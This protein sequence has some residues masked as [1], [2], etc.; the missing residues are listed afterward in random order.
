[1]SGE[2]AAKAKSQYL[3]ACIG[4]TIT[5]FTWVAKA[6][7][8]QNM[9]DSSSKHDEP[10]SLP[11]CNS[12]NALTDVGH[13]EPLSLLHLNFA[14]TANCSNGTSSHSGSSYDKPF[15]IAYTNG[16]AYSLFL[17][18]FLAGHPELLRYFLRWLRDA[19]LSFFCGRLCGRPV[20][21]RHQLLNSSLSPPPGALDASDDEAS[22][23]SF[24]KS[25]AS[26]NGAASPSGVV[27][28]PHHKRLHVQAAGEGEEQLP[29]Y[30]AKL[31]PTY[32]RSVKTALV[33][34][35]L[36]LC[37]GWMA[38]ASLSR[39]SLAVN[40]SIWNSGC[41]LV[42]LLEGSFL[43]GHSLRDPQ[44]LLSVMVSLSGVAVLTVA[45][46]RE[47]PKD[48]DSAT[49]TSLVGVLMT[50][51]A[52]LIYSIYEVV[53]KFVSEEQPETGASTTA[54]ADALE[55]AEASAQCAA[56]GELALDIGAPA[57]VGA[58]AAAE[59]AH[60]SDKVQGH[61]AAMGPI[62]GAMLF[63]GTLGMGIA[64]FAWIGLF[65]LDATGVEPWQRPEGSD[66]HMILATMGLDCVLNIA[67]LGSIA[68]S[69]ALFVQCGT[70]L[71]IPVSTLWDFVAHH[72]VPSPL[73]VIG[74]AILVLG[75]LGLNVRLPCL[76]KEKDHG[77]LDHQLD[78]EAAASVAAAEDE[79]EQA[80]GN[81]ARKLR[82]MKVGGSASSSSSG[83]SSLA[84]SPL[85][86]NSDE[87][88]ATRT[89]LRSP[90]L[91]EQ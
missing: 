91:E 18:V 3:L 65:I 73:N 88:T 47:H 32:A 53:F 89:V 69:S 46:T 59:A 45:S 77:T 19:C 6:A 90:L 78:A 7:L 52:M 42:F 31:V 62:W 66:L 44:K 58:L 23:P 24:R 34:S 40:T 10:S 33:L 61:S 25:T 55:D 79:E 1:M 26:V 74:M 49:A 38:N 20:E 14:A 29:T 57:A 28:S 15:F 11:P 36:Y 17:F 5:V 35:L 43:P 67:I 21:A 72:S 39:T 56:E 30:L 87:A 80:S 13:D 48:G 84:P 16:S 71:T 68:L 76:P 8:V 54:N 37:C 12:T 83:S 81:G 75:F 4:V 60:P 64:C 86:Y 85:G 9:S 2:P 63:L 82:P 50:L 70:L 22:P 27:S 51:G 41:A